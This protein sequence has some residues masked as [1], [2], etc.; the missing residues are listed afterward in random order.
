MTTENR[1]DC[2]TSLVDW[3]Q[4]TFPYVTDLNLA[5]EVLGIPEEEWTDMPN[6][7]Y[8]YMKQKTHGKIK[9]LYEGI[10][11]RMGIHIQISG[12]GCREYETYYG[13]YNSDTWP[14]LFGRV[15]DCHGHFTRV[16]L[17]IDEF[18]Y[19]GEK[20]YFSVSQLLARV[21][22]NQCKSKFK[23]VQAM[24]K[25][26]IEGGVNLGYTIYFGSVLSD[27]QARVY[28]KNHERRNE[29]FELQEQLTTWNRF[30]VEMSDERAQAAVMTILSGVH[31]GAVVYGIISH[32]IDFLDKV[33]D[34]SNKARWPR[35]KFWDDYLNAASKLRL[36]VK[37]PDKTIPEK[38]SW[39][40]KFVYPTL[41]EVWVANGCPGEDWLVELLDNGME[42]M[43]EQQWIRAESFM[44]KMKEEK[45]RLDEKK[46]AIYERKQEERMRE[47]YKQRH[48]YD[49]AAEP[50]GQEKETRSNESPS[51]NDLV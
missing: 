18:R 45:D 16:D 6:G 34:D 41:T 51:S 27:I 44:V 20:P 23:T 2:L 42:R 21:K 25:M 31:P 35:S 26:K 49:F 3:V 46:K 22:R 36:A 5:Y 48:K 11:A 10:D 29:G 47:V 12:Q 39:L 13:N 24:Q 8:R 14:C 9:L 19:N 4:F 38:E 15:L 33:K 43:T 40:K 30:E 17:A 1:D 28:E 50:F 37:A 32:Y 7:L